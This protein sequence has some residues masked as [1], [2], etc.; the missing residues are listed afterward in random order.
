MS[1]DVIFKIFVFISLTYTF[2]VFLKTRNYIHRLP[3]M[4]KGKYEGLEKFGIK[5]LVITVSLFLISIFVLNKLISIIMSCVIVYM[6]LV[7]ISE[8]NVLKEY[9][10]LKRKMK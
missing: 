7:L 3:K 5:I 8:L 10:Y 1:V 6:L 4:T 9:V 2:V